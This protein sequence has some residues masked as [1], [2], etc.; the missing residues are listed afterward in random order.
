VANVSLTS[1]ERY[2]HNRIPTNDTTSGN[3]FALLE[4]WY[5]ALRILVQ[6]WEGDVHTASHWLTMHQAINLLPPSIQSSDDALRLKNGLN[7]EKNQSQLI[8]LRDQV[9]SKKNH[10]GNDFKCIIFVQQRVTA[11][12]IANYLNTIDATLR[13]G[14]V[15]SRGSSVTPSINVTPTDVARTIQAF[16][17]GKS[18][19]LVATAVVEEGFDVPEANVVILY[20]HMKD[21]VE[22]CQRFGRARAR[23]CHIVVM[24]ERKDRPVKFLENVRNLQHD[25]VRSYNPEIC[26][27]RKTCPSEKQKHMDRERTGY[28]KVLCNLEK[29]LNSPTLA[30]HEYS[31]TTNASIDEKVYVE[32]CGRFVCEITYSTTLR[33]LQVTGTATSKKGAKAECCRNILSRLKNL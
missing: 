11:H 2:A 22:L 30:F 1:W 16:R 6:T 32:S 15:A 23:E 10:F 17:E 21:S 31:K 3:I 13:T 24:D 25:I 8:S 26:K 27:A 12:V 19:V 14:F 5:V 20:D 29:C 4:I 7:D 33:T 28:L 18:C 9:E